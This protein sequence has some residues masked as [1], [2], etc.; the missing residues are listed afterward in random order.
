MSQF[1]SIC[2]D[3]FLFSGHEISQYATLGISE[4]CSHKFSSQWYGGGGCGSSSKMQ[5]ESIQCSILG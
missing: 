5:Q 4:N 2:I 1:L 3:S